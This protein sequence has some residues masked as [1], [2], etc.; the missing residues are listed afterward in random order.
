MPGARL[1]GEDAG[2]LRG[3]LEPSPPCQHVLNSLATLN[4]TIGDRSDMRR[5]RATSPNSFSPDG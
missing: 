2:R 4:Q 5:A 1:L 3:E